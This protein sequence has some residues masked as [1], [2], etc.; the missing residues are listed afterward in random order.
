MST[1]IEWADKSWNPITGCT[2][3]SAGC[4]H[5]YAKRL[6]EGRLRGRYGYSQ[7]EPFRVAIHPT[8]L[9]Q[10]CHWRKPCRVFVCSMSDIFHEDVSSQYID[11]ILHTIWACQKHTFIVLT[12]RPELIK[13]KFYTR[14]AKHIPRFMETFPAPLPNLWL[15]V[16]VESPKYLWR[17][18]KLL[19][20]QAAVRFVSFEP[21][22]GPVDLTGLHLDR[23]SQSLQPYF[24]RLDWVIVG[25]ETGPGARPMHPDWARQI[26][27][28]CVAANVPFFFKQMSRKAAIPEDL[29]IREWPK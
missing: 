12:K 13:E 15:G 27:D 7:L 23:Y 14:F 28:D 25:G 5:C 10:P 29:L 11:K 3:V 8:R 20:I 22:L 18:D 24:D 17:I 21:L 4:E 6:A 26:R 1:K 16:T 19:E 9:K 2:P